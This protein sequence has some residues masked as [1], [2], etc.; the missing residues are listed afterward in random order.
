MTQGV[1]M[2][3]TQSRVVS[4]GLFF[5]FIFLSG[6][7]LSRSGRPYN[8][9]LINIHKLI[10]LAAGVFL[11]MTVYRIH[12]AAPLRPVQIAAIVVTV[13]IFVGT[14]AAGGLVSID[15]AGD[16]GNINQS[17][18]AAISMAHR[19]F[20]YLAVLSTAVTLYLLLSRKW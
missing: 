17:I 1:E 19:I 2:N 15:A 11:V 3:I 18:R 4:A 6:F 14:V 20:P 9:I 10:G 8:A 7:W 12:Q 13:L 16:L 5:L